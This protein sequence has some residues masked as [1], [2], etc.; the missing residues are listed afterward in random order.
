LILAAATAAY[1]VLASRSTPT[2]VSPN[3]ASNIIG[4]AL[5]TIAPTT[6][7]TPTPTASPSPPHIGSIV[8]AGNWRYQVQQVDVAKIYTSGSGFL[9]TSYTA[10]GNW[11]IVLIQLTNIGNRNYSINAFD[12]ELRDDKG[13]KYNPE[14]SYAFNLPPGYMNFGEQMPPGVPQLARLYFDVTPGTSGM[15]LYL[16]NVGLLEKAPFI[17]LY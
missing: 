4:A 10:K 6:Q 16:S 9:A 12:F 13:I 5:L 15:Y 1:I 8:E 3:S 7:P 2:L 11:V 14:S 17:Y